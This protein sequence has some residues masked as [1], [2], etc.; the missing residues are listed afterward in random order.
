MGSH[1]AYKMGICCERVVA[2]FATIRFFTGMG[3][4]VLLEIA[5]CC[6][7]IVALGTNKGFLSAVNSLVDFQERRILA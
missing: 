7:S 2:L 3:S 6:A 1:V 4:H 5:S